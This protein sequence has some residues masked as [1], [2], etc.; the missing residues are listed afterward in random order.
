MRRIAVRVSV[1]VV[2]ALLVSAPVF[3]VTVAGCH[4]P[5]DQYAMVDSTAEPSVLP[6]TVYDFDPQPAGRVGADTGSGASRVLGADE[7]VKSSMTDS[8]DSPGETMGT[9][10]TVHVVAKGDTLFG[11]ARRYYGNPAKWKDIAKANQDDLRDPNLLR[12][13]QRLVIP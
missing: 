12:V 7:P 1:P 11:L 2:C 4:R 13:G 5:A 3:C 9:P 6:A 10:G 8:A